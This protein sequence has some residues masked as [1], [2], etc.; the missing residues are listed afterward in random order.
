[1]PPTVAS[2]SDRRRART[3]TALVEAARRVFAEQGAEATTI[4]QITD[5]A[6]VAKGSFYNHFESREDIQ[7]CVAEAVLEEMGAALD[8]DLAQRESDPAR[9]VA[10]S[11]LSTLRT[12]LEDPALGGF[13]LQNPD[14]VDLPAALG[15]R[16]RRD[17]AR[18]RRAGRFAVD[19]VDAVLAMLAGA[20]L[21]WL[22][23]RGDAAARPK[24]Q[25]RFL[26][27][28]LR[29]LGLPVDEADAIAVETLET[30]GR[31]RT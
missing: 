22:R 9:V 5:A 18:G 19:D 24:E 28:A 12:C 30:L 29:M 20:G 17:L 14:A 7:R 11:L 2:R 16:A 23:A 8:R 4:Q 31:R 26:A 1:M 15:P 6:D 10:A 21:G 27:L 3:R 13:L 25:A